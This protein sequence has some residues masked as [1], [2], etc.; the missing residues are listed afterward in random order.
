MITGSWPRGL[1]LFPAVACLLLVILASTA[2]GSG[3]LPGEG[4]QRLRPPDYAEPGVRNPLTG[5]YADAGN[6]ERLPLAFV[7]DNHPSARPQSGLPGSDL[8]VEVPVEGGITRLLTLVWSDTPPTVG[9]VRSAR[10]YYLDLARSLEA[11]FVHVGG[12]PQAYQQ[13]N[14]SP[15]P[16]FNAMFMSHG[17]RWVDFR[18]QPHSLYSVP[19]DLFAEAQARGWTG[20]PET[21]DPGWSFLGPRQV[22]SG[23]S[24]HGISARMAGSWAEEMSFE[25]R[26][27]DGLYEKHVSG[28]LQ[29]DYDSGEPVLFANL[30]L[31]E[32]PMRVIPG[33]TEGRMELFLEGSGRADIFVRGRHQTGEWQGEGGFPAVTRENGDP[34]QLAPGLTWVI[35]VPPSAEVRTR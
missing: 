28:R 9:P 5:L 32:V 8:V 6:L 21:L 12:S 19:G 27:S 22:P 13:L 7:V 1:L 29:V 23:D 33:D 11:V 30:M 26:P 24:V 34:V 20:P 25:F 31:L 4:P 14:R 17:F 18:R 2:D 3:L 16:H 10:H 15:Q 35:F